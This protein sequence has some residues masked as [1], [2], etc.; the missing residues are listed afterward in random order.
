MKWQPLPAVAVVVAVAAAFG[1]T[2]IDPATIPAA[3]RAQPERTTRVTCQSV[4]G[5]SYGVTGA[6]TLTVLDGDAAPEEVQPPLVSG[7]AGRAAVVRGVAVQGGLFGGDGTWSPC[8]TAATSGT[9][10]WPD[11]TKAEL[12]LTNADSS[13]ASVDVRLSGPDGEVESLGARGIELAPQETRQ[14]PISVLMKGTRGPVAAHWSAA[15]GRV[16]ALGVTTGALRSR[17]PSGVVSPSVSASTRHLLPGQPAQ[18]GATVVMANPGTDRVSAQIAFRSTTS[19]F[20]PQGGEDVSIPGG[21]VVA[22][23]FGSATQRKAGTFDVRADGPVQAVLLPGGAPTGVGAPATSSTSLRGV[24]PGGSALQVTNPGDEPT[25]AR[26]RIGD[27]TSEHTI[28]AGTT[29]TVPVPGRAPLDVRVE[30]DDPVVAAAVT[31][32]GKAVVAFG[33]AEPPSVP[34]TDAV[35]RPGMR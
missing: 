22:V 10:L 2:T 18:D 14:V 4:T 33:P 25:R 28:E 11:V 9:V 23:A 21:S 26:T 34:E 27:A 15:R 7:G 30:A 3:T 19:T 6:G 12:L 24:A 5:G 20:T 13:D 31:S 29:V 8:Q 1:L 17:A 16:T 35:L 32:G